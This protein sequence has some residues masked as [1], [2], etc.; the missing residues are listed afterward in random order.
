MLCK[1][2]DV[3]AC[4]VTSYKQSLPRHRYDWSHH[5]HHRP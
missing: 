1:F 3:M 4:Q 2:R 5:L